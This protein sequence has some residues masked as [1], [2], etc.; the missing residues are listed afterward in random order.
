MMSS[1]PDLVPRS[2]MDEH[3]DVNLYLFTFA[4]CALSWFALCLTAM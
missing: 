4:V 3:V 1:V 2:C